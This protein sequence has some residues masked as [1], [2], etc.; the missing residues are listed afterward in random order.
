MGWGA[1]GPG[2]AVPG[3]LGSLE[4]LCTEAKGFTAS[5]R[6]AGEIYLWGMLHQ[7]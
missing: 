6:T 1:S 7:V 4:K 3:H 5:G 2:Q